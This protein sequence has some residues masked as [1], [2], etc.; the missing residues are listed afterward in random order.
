MEI[1]V[2]LAYYERRSPA[3]GRAVV[4]DCEGGFVSSR[5]WN[6]CATTLEN[7]SVSSMRRSPNRIEGGAMIALTSDLHESNRM[8]GV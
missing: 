7:S 4:T 6:L 8:T 2:R 1:C 5:V 3:I